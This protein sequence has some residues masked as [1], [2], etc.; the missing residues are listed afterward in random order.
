[1]KVQLTNVVNHIFSFSFLLSIFTRKGFPYQP[2]HFGKFLPATTT[3]ILPTLNG[4]NPQS[5]VWKLSQRLRLFSSEKPKLKPYSAVWAAYQD[6]NSATH[7]II[8]VVISQN[9]GSVVQQSL[10]EFGNQANK[11]DAILF[12]LWRKWVEQFGHAEVRKKNDW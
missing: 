11:P 7:S 6:I 1:M 12:L 5:V 4:I 3:K 2:N 8:N 10:H 9:D